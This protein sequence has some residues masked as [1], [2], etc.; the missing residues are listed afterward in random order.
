M[1]STGRRWIVAVVLGFV[2]VCII[3]SVADEHRQTPPR[4]VPPAASRPAATQYVTPHS[5]TLAPTALPAAPTRPWTPSRTPP[6][7]S[8]A[9]YAPPNWSA[10][11]RT[12][13]SGVGASYGSDDDED[14]VDADPLDDPFADESEEVDDGLHSAT[15]DYFNPATG[16]MGTYTLDVQVDGG[17]VTTIYFP[18]GGWLDDTHF[19]PADLEE[20]RASI[21]D[22]EGRSWDVELDQ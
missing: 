6:Y 5:P 21:V 22:D 1:T 13:Y 7:Q 20:G 2:A 16:T 14:D 12:S 8:P 3:S 9:S 19:E 10:P 18:Q 17:Q 11:P 4:A 15:I